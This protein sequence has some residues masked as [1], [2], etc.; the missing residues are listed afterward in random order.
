MIIEKKMIVKSDTNIS[1]F[2]W[3][4]DGLTDGRDFLNNEFLN[5]VWFHPWA[6]VEITDKSFT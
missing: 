5:S 1:S 2:L 4:A 6:R 3:G